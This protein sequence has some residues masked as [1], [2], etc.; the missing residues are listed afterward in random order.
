MSTQPNELEAISDNE[1]EAA[2]GGVSADGQDLG[3]NVTF[4]GSQNLEIGKLEAKAGDTVT[5]G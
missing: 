2:A 5:F 1:L 4:D 3:K